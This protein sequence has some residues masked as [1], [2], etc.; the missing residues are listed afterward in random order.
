MYVYTSC[1]WLHVLYHT[2]YAY[3]WVIYNIYNCVD[4]AL[5]GCILDSRH[6]HRY[7]RVLP[8]AFTQSIA[9]AA[10]RHQRARA[11]SVLPS[12]RLGL[13]RGSLRL[14]HQIQTRRFRS[15]VPRRAGRTPRALITAGVAA[16]AELC[17]LSRRCHHVLLRARHRGPSND[18]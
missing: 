5:C 15:L 18:D 9:S 3:V 12:A 16:P 8:A 13:C 17:R 1:V 2:R 10:Q 11:R 14:P 6:A 7:T 4:P